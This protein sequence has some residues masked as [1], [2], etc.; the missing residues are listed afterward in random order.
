MARLL[1]SVDDVI[2]ALG[3]ASSVAALTGVHAPA[4]SNWRARGKI[5]QGKFLVIK[6]A[7]DAREMHVAPSV[8]GFKDS[9]V[10]A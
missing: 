2:D 10:R 3:G 1:N 7:L 8:F 9:E 4:V 6:A 5:S